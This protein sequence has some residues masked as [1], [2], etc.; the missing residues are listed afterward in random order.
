MPRKGASIHAV[1]GNA[2]G[3]N[4]DA[5]RNPLFAKYF[6]CNVVKPSP[7]P[8]PRPQLAVEAAIAD[9]LRRY[10]WP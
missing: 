8:L 1:K 2:H 5:L 6:L 10:A 4:G 9:R 7:I 3:E